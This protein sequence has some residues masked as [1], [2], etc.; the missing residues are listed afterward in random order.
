MSA[1][2]RFVSGSLAGSS[3]GVGDAVG[4]GRS[5]S[6]AVRPAE[7]DVSGHHAV[8]SPGESGLLLEV[9]GRAG[10]VVDGRAV[11]P[12]AS[13]ALAP[14]ARVR[15]GSSLEFEVAGDAPAADETAAGETAADE[16]AAD[17]TTAPDV[18][19]GADETRA[20]ETQAATPAELER[21]RGMHQAR[22]RRSV[23]FRVA[24]VAAAFLAALGVS[25]WR[26][27]APE[28]ERLLHPR[29]EKGDTLR[30]KVEIDA[31]GP[32][33]AEPPFLFVYGANAP[34]SRSTD[35]AG[36]RWTTVGGRLRT[37]RGRDVDFP[38]RACAFDDPEGLR[39]PR[40]ERFR[41]WLEAVAPE[42]NW[43]L[44]GEE[45][46][47]RLRFLGGERGLGPGIPYRQWRYKTG[48]GGVQRDGRVAFFRAGRRCYAVCWELESSVFALSRRA[49][50]PGR[51]LEELV[52]SPSSFAEGRWEGAPE[53]GL[54][55]DPAA[56]ARSPLEWE[57]T[58]TRLREALVA[59]ALA[60]EPT[61]GTQAAAGLS[62]LRRA[63][64]A[65]WK[66][67]WARRVEAAHDPRAAAA[68]DAEAVAAFRGSD[69]RRRDL[70]RDKNWWK[71]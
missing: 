39:A 53:S 38:V 19:D 2:I 45:P 59:A 1:S 68:V 60:G 28:T 65:A 52:V 27:R 24:L 29:G 70:L 55:P 67:F 32:D 63:K 43:T 54:S 21:L 69:D 17:E 5:R 22:R 33:V 42:R 37:S 40:E 66:D 18:D 64:D 61:A 34:V 62:A 9:S 50:A 57:E 26:Q 51:A 13:V 35:G 12:G 8:V 58:E 44:L 14:G 41:A 15:L 4:I 46:P 48:E 31:P 23:L 71:K 30:T 11:S 3:F 47:A 49:G 20:L 10:A 56:T 7:P 25:L 36:R 6:C 16:T